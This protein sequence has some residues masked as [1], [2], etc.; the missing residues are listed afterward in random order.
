VKNIGLGE[1]LQV[2]RLEIAKNE[3]F[4][5]AKSLNFLVFELFKV[6]HLKEVPTMNFDANNCRF[7]DSNDL[8]LVNK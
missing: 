6:C 3:G 8:S 2:Q 7:P 1:F 4:G 5:L